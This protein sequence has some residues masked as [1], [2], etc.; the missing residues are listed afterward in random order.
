MASSRRTTSWRETRAT[1]SRPGFSPSAP[2]R[3]RGHSCFRG[4]ILLAPVNVPE[5]GGGKARC[6]PWHGQGMV[7]A[8]VISEAELIDQLPSALQPCAL[9]LLDHDWT[10][11]IEPDRPTDVRKRLIAQHACGAEVLVIAR[12][13]ARA[14]RPTKWRACN[15][16]Y[17]LRASTESPWLKADGMQTL[18]DYLE[19]LQIDPAR[20]KPF[21][22]DPVATP[23]ARNSAVCSCEKRRFTHTKAES[24]LLGAKLKRAEGDA[25]RRECRAYRCDDDARVWHLTSRPV[26]R[27]SDA[28]AQDRSAA[29]A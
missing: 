7:T 14:G 16:R 25:R 13:T 1:T 18:T 19:S 4:T 6:D 10:L 22:Q 27:S 12:P 2:A 8:T 23:N 5:P 24:V 9:T 28:D 17:F 3:G 15:N 20:I 11:A 29:S 21:A 26:W